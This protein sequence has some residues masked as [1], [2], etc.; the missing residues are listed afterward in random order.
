MIVQL[1]LFGNEIARKRRKK[2]RKTDRRQHRKEGWEDS[3]TPALVA[4]SLLFAEDTSLIADHEKRVEILA[5]RHANRLPIFR[6]GVI[7]PNAIVDHETHLPT[8]PDEFVSRLVDM[9]FH[10]EIK[11]VYEVEGGRWR[12][13]P[14]CTGCKKHPRPRHVCLGRFA[15]K[16]EATAAYMAFRRWHDPLMK[17]D[18]GAEED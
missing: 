1:D 11:G 7:Y 9:F 10:S 17:M 8:D 13:Y 6:P 5:A 4:E 15:T 3:D 16:E 14:W 18:Y 12:A 2:K